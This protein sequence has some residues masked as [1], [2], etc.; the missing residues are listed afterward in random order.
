MIAYVGVEGGGDG[1]GA[2]GRESDEGWG[3]G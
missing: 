3:L 1:D 2:G